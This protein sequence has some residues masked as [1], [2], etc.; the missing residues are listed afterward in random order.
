MKTIY[1][2]LIAILFIGYLLISAVEAVNGCDASIIT[3]QEMVRSAD[4]IVHAKAV[5]FVDKEGVNFKITEVLKGINVATT[6][7][8]KG[9]LEKRDDFNKG[10]IPY[11]HVRSSGH[12]PC[13]A[14]EYKEDG[15]FLLFLKRE[16]G[17]HT[18]Y[19]S[20]LAPTNEQL[21]PDD[22]WLKWVKEQLKQ[23]TL[24]SVS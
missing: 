5:K 12:G 16:K 10:D 24:K 15:E 1:S 13:F 2:H 18:P 9:S 14:Y 17:E 8:I 23:F 7:T 3:P 6:I 20:P 4:I 19:W 21:R 22:S 11:R